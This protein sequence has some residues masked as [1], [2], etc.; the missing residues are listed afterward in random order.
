MPK[1]PI[2]KS[3]KTRRNLDETLCRVDQPPEL[4]NRS[5][6]EIVGR[7]GERHPTS[8]ILPTP[9][10]D[11]QHAEDS[12]EDPDIEDWRKALGDKVPNAV[13][14]FLQYRHRKWEWGGWKPT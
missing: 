8:A 12:I 5:P 2:K 9:V 14:E 7:G 4:D 10:A 6:D 1:Q 11:G 13:K 3:D